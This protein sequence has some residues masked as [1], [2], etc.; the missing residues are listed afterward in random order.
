MTIIYVSRLRIMKSVSQVCEVESSGDIFAALND[1]YLDGSIFETI[2]NLTPSIK[3]TVNVC[4]FMNNAKN[5]DL[6]P[7]ITEDG[8][9]YNFN[10]MN[11]NDVVTDE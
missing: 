6:F 4:R 2:Y 5:C 1:S 10:G 3:D 8:V 7:I 11:K 9:C